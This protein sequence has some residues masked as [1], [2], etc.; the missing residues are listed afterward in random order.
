M[1]TPC[2]PHASGIVS[3]EN[4]R[5][6]VEATLKEHKIPYKLKDKQVECLEHVVAGHDVLGILPTGY[7][8]TVIYALLPSVLAHLG[9]AGRKVLVISPLVALM[10]DQVAR[11]DLLGIKAVQ[12]NQQTSNST[13]PDSDIL[14]LSPEALFKGNW[15][16]VLCQPSYQDSIYCI[17][18]DEAHCVV[19]WGNE[20]RPDYARIGELRSVLQKSSILALTAT[21]TQ[22]MQQDI[23]KILCMDKC[24]VVTT[25]LDRGNIFYHAVRAPLLIADTF[26]WMAD[27]LRTLKQNCN[28]YIIYCRNIKS[29][30]ALY[31]YFLVELGDDSWLGPPGIRNAL[32]SMYHHSTPVKNKR[33]IEKSFKET[34]SNIRVVIATVAFGMG[35]DASDI[36]MVIHWGAARTF[37]GFTQ[38]AG[39][40]G[41]NGQQSYSTVYFHA[42][43]TTLCATDITM[44]KYCKSQDICRRKILLDHFCC[45]SDIAGTKSAKHFCCDICHSQCGCGDCPAYPGLIPQRLTDDDL[46]AAACKIDR[47]TH[48][49][50]DEQRSAIEKDIISFRESQGQK[51]FISPTLM[52]GLTDAIITDIV[53]NVHYIHCQ[54]DLLT[55]YVYDCGVAAEIWR[56]ISNYID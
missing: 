53:Q 2:K 52:T 7:G 49:M 9:T 13:D 25:D 26:F 1:A 37:E 51:G 20:F 32:F 29:C 10:A 4:L 19:Q 5:T 40:A 50:N 12:L 14:L 41:R 21:A 36:Y 46:V 38:E 22:Q 42:V 3:R 23:M 55:E 24:E 47:Q 18:I 33:H 11:L 28:K 27:E 30:A 43:D 8:K 56:I 17:V 54:E 45:I 35:V 48:D 15:Q 6:A 31:K 34:N 39:R 44:Q 16:S